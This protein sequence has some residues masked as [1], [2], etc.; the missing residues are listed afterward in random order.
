MLKELPAPETAFALDLFGTKITDE[1]L[2]ELVHLKQLTYL[3][4]AR[5]G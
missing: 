4:L 2:K 3:F 1:G 5:P